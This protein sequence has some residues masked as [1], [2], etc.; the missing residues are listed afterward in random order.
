MNSHMIG[1]SGW[2]T[3]QF[4]DYQSYGL[5]ARDWSRVLNMAEHGSGGGELGNT[6][7]ELSREFPSDRGAY[8]RG[9]L[10]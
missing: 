9:L 3:Y 1:N 10:G 5:D 7:S 2:G 6:I 8:N 4:H